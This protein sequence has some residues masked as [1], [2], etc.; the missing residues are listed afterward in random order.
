MSES[1]EQEYPKRSINVDDL[2]FLEQ[3]QHELNT[4]PHLCQADPRFWVIRDYEYREATESDEIDA[5][6]LF[7]DGEGETMSLEEAVMRAYKDELDFGGEDHARE[8]LEDNWLELDESGN[9]KGRYAT[10]SDITFRN[11]IENYAKHNMLDCVFLTK[12]LKIVADTM[13]LTL[14][15]AKDHLETNYYH[16][17][18]EARTYA[19]TAWRSPDVAQLIKL[20]HEVDFNELSELVSK[21]E[22]EREQ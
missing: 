22:K 18:N 3:L 10:I 12:Q 20:L 9:V 19:M 7:E 5:V 2:G 8:W 11:V 16:Y 21:A 17:T 1:V 13:F 15:E 6:E 4:Q 14:R